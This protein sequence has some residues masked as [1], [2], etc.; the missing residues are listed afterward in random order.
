ME[1]LHFPPMLSPDEWGKKFNEYVDALHRSDMNTSQ[2]LLF[3]TNAI[4]KLRNL[5]KA[6][7]PKREK[8]DVTHSDSVIVK[9]RES[10]EEFFE[11]S[12]F[13]EPKADKDVTPLIEP[14]KSVP[15]KKARSA[16]RSHSAKHASKKAK[17]DWHT[18]PPD[19]TPKR[20]RKTPKKLLDFSY[21]ISARPR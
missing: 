19:S 12:L 7:K 21:E 1:E 3:Y 10:E 11:P 17:E 16:K 14:D 6:F 2:K 9:N 4:S 8:S 20:K 15:R 5:R 13:Q 18:H